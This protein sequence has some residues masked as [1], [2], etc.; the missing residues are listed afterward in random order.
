MTEKLKA[1][2]LY[3]TQV[4]ANLKDAEIR[5]NQVQERQ[6]KGG[7]LTELPFIA[8]Q[9]QIG[10]LQQQL[11]TQKIAV[12]QLKD[13]YREK[14]PKMVEAMNTLVQTQHDF[15]RAVKSAA[16]SIESEHQTALRNE[17]EARISLAKQE[18]ES[19]E[20]DRYQVEYSNLERD[21]KI[22]EQILE[23]ILS[24]SRETFMT[25]TIE[26]QNARVVDSRS[27]GLEAQHA[28]N[29]P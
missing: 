24:R 5:W 16:A 8:N 9:S 14:H 21:F 22:N 1:L 6:A 28:K 29:Y 2:S 13:R 12:A 3:F 4:S 23:S 25:S 17:K 10:P 11:A 27:A 19:L 7:D 26:T 18:A 20:L 15:D